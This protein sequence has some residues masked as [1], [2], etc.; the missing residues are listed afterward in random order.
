MQ[1]CSVPKKITLLDPFQDNP[2]RVASGRAPLKP[3]GA[4]STIGRRAS[5]L[6]SAIVDYHGAG[7]RAAVR[8][9]ALIRPGVESPCKTV[10]R[11]LI[12]GAGLPEH[13]PGVESN[14]PRVGPIGP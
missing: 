4:E 13:Q 7:K 3:P 11:L 1:P 9:F 12:V 6:R 8:A 14:P 5:A 10:L 2:F